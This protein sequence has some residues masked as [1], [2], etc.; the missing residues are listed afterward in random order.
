MIKRKYD[1]RLIVDFCVFTS[2]YQN[3]PSVI[4]KLLN[5]FMI[6][7]GQFKYEL[8]KL[9]KSTNN[10]LSCFGLIEENMDL[11][12]IHLAVLEKKQD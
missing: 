8:A 12:P 4:I 10:L 11:S 9:Q 1:N 3:L 7:T 6:R 5:N 2:S